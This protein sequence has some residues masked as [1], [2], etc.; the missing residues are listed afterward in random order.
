MTLDFCVTADI[1]T[2]ILLLVITNVVV[3]LVV[4]MRTYSG[5]SNVVRDTEHANVASGHIHPAQIHHNG[6]ANMA[7][8]RIYPA[9]MHNNGVKWNRKKKKKLT[10]Y[11]GCGHIVR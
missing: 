2:V 3:L 11:T 4:L 9:Q 8:G 1:W 10:M 5:T 6:H 7:S